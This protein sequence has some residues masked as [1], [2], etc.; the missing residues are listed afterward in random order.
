MSVLTRLQNK[1]EE[2]IKNYE[3]LKIENNQLK[4]R[5][6]NPSFGETSQKELIQKLKDDLENRDKEI[7][8]LIR[9]VEEFLE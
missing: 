8:Q 7:D 3:L 4:K 5:L 6:Q 2:L 9:K 1:I